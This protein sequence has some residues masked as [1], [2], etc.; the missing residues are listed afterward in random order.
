MRSP[1]IEL[2]ADRGG[3]TLLG[4]WLVRTANTPPESLAA[5]FFVDRRLPVCY[6]SIVKFGAIPGAAPGP[7]Q[8]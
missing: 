6:A 7:N 3:K 4:R 2:G 1:W 5:P 8:A